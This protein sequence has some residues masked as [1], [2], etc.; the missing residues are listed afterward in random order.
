MTTLVLRFSIDRGPAAFDD[1]S[2]LVL[3]VRIPFTFTMP[4]ETGDGTIERS[5]DEGLLR[6]SERVPAGPG[7]DSVEEQ[8]R[9]SCGQA[10]LPSAVNLDG[11]K[12]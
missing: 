8:G 5:M 1:A 6:E 12:S 10:A 11:T 2:G 7:Q 9:A 3:P 4:A